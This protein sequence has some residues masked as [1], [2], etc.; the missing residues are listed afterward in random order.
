MRGGGEGE[1][2]GEAE[3]ECG[4]SIA[5]VSGTGTYDVVVAVQRENVPSHGSWISDPD[6]SLGLTA[7]ILECYYDWR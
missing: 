3:G 1:A 5:G 2:E 7:D 4:L 6:P